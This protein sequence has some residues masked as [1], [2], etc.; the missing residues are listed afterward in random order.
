MVNSLEKNNIFP[1]KIKHSASQ[2][3]WQGQTAET[4]EEGRKESNE[5]G[6]VVPVSESKTTE[7]RDEM[8]P[9]VVRGD[10]WVTAGENR[11]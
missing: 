3:P 6:K 11:G 1:P 4:K 10:S 8:M 9:H 7:I 2:T 5:E